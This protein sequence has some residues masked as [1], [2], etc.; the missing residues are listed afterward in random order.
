[1]ETRTEIRR[2]LRTA[3]DWAVVVQELEREA[4]ATTSLADK[5]DRLYETGLLAEEVRASRTL[6]LICASGARR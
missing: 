1:M 6:Q 3:R 5:S 2:R 4:D